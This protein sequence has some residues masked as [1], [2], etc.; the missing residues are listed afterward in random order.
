MD[1]SVF[2]TFF[3]ISVGLSLGFFLFLFL[4]IYFLYLR[5]K[6]K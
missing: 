6:I 2:Q 4:P 3:E 5:K 1:A